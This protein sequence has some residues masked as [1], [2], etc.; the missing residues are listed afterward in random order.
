MPLGQEALP[1]IQWVQMQQ[2]TGAHRSVLPRTEETGKGLSGQGTRP[3]VKVQGYVRATRRQAGQE[4]R[5]QRKLGIRSDIRGTLQSPLL[6]DSPPI[7]HTQ[8][9]KSQQVHIRWRQ[10]LAA[11]GIKQQAQNAKN[12][13][14]KGNIL[15]EVFQLWLCNDL[16]SKDNSTVILG[17]GK[18]ILGTVHPCANREKSASLPCSTHIRGPSRRLTFQSKEQGSW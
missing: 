18:N 17:F 15:E 6:G 13:Y 16:F 7:Q 3:G 9:C 8:H 5:K 4:M 12:T 10:H 1:L 14:F 11:P 2:A